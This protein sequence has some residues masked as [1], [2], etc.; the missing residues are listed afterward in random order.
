MDTIASIDLGTNTFHLLIAEYI[1]GTPR[2]LFQETIAVKLGEGGITKGHIN[3]AAFDRGLKALKSFKQ[4]LEHYGVSQIKAVATSALR[5]A[6]NGIDF[7][8]SIR[9]ETGIKPEVITGDR[10][11]ELI[12]YGV[13]AAIDMGQECC[14]IMDIGGGSV[15]FI[16]CNIEQIFWKKSFDIGVARLMEEF[17]HSD[18]IAET[19]IQKLFRHLDGVIFELNQK[20]AE[21]MPII[22][23][24]S[25]GVFETY[26]QLINPELKLGLEEPRFTIQLIDFKRIAEIILKSKHL[27]RSQIP[28]IIPLRVNMIVTSTL[29][30]RY[31]LNLHPFQQMMLSTYSLKEGLIFEWI[32][33]QKRLS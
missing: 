26:A 15:E 22:L 29:L 7:L 18:P 23:I 21:Y 25:G 1:E 13:K 20:L 17:H 3:D 28:A 31:I 6:S 8:E 24:G 30:T 2:V 4:S 14:L 33:W 27:Q 9:I 12:Y 19:D 5:T 10:E 11:A 16:I 32:E